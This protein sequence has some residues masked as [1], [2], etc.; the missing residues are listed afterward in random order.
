MSGVEAAKVL[1]PNLWDYEKSEI[2]EYETVYY[3]N[4]QERVKQQNLNQVI[5]QRNGSSS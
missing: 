2:L 1:G 5:T 4:V 3:F